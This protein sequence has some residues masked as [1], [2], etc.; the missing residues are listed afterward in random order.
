MFTMWEEKKVFCVFGFCLLYFFLEN[1]H[2][3]YLLSYLKSNLLYFPPNLD[4]IACEEDRLKL[5]K[6]QFQASHHGGPVSDLCLVQKALI[7]RWNVLL[8]GT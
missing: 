6:S 2:Y 1:L 4:G 3:N 8:L 7:R 5:D